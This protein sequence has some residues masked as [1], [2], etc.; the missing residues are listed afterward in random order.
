VSSFAQTFENAIG[1]VKRSVFSAAQ[2]KLQAVS[3]KAP[4]TKHRQSDLDTPKKGVHHF[5]NWPSRLGGF[6]AR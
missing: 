6:F 5:L 4:T 2:V 1:R 3:S